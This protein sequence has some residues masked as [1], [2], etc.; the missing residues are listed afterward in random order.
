MLA[1]GRKASTLPRGSLIIDGSVVVN[2]KWSRANLQR[3]SKGN[4]CI[5]LGG[6]VTVVGECACVSED[7][8]GHGFSCT[9]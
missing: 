6:D 7:H 2:E 1:A 3:S 4:H 8:S 9:G 5:F